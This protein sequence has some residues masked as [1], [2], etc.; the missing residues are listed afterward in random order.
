VFSGLRLS[1]TLSSLRRAFSLVSQQDSPLSYDVFQVPTFPGFIGEDMVF[2]HAWSSSPTCH[3]RSPLLAGVLL[4]SLGCPHSASAP[5]PLVSRCSAPFSSTP[6]GCFHF[7]LSSV[8]DR[9]NHGQ[10]S[11]QPPSLSRPS[12][13]DAF[14]PSVADPDI[15]RTLHHRLIFT[16]FFYKPCPPVI[17]SFPVSSPVLEA[18]SLL[19]LCGPS[20]F[21]FFTFLLA[22][23]SQSI[24][25]SPRPTPSAP[26]SLA[27][28]L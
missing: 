19:L 25:S 9:V 18:F 14:I 10:N 13:S 24:R 16:G 1:H 7:F 21:H 26:R 6:N 17:V 4:L 12:G 3:P 2:G 23:V 27:A 15:S 22:D 11:P 20:S 28:L 5:P 8:C